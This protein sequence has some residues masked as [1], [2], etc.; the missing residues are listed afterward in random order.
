MRAPDDARDTCSGP[1]HAISVEPIAGERNSRFCAPAVRELGST[2]SSPLRDVAGFHERVTGVSARALVARDDATMPSPA[3]PARQPRPGRRRAA[4]AG[5]RVL[6]DRSALPS[7]SPW[8]SGRAGH[9]RLADAREHR[10]QR[11]QHSRRHARTRAMLA[12]A[13]RAPRPR[14]LGDNRSRA[15]AIERGVD[16]EAG[17]GGP[18]SAGRKSSRC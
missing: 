9:P 17:G 5:L 15:V 4:R 16:L 7:V 11:R 10:R 13:S 2:C 12:S 3:Q 6:D 1:G 8:R 14:H 18:R